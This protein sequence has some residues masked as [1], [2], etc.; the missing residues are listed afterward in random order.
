MENKV[1]FVHQSVLRVKNN[2]LPS[3]SIITVNNERLIKIIILCFSPISSN[4]A[5]AGMNFKI[6]QFP[7]LTILLLVIQQIYL[8]DS[9][10]KIRYHKALNARKYGVTL[11]TANHYTISDREGGDIFGFTSRYDSEED[12]KLNPED[13]RE[14]SLENGFENVELVDDIILKYNDDLPEQPTARN[15]PPRFLKPL[16]V[17]NIK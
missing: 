14:H 4:L 17:R 1:V 15:I 9:A 2:S 16:K 10:R 7:I 11:T 8:C 6:K 5:I 3:L 12:I 13:F